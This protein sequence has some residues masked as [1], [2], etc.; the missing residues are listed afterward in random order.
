MIARIW[1]GLARDDGAE[2]Y[3]R[4]LEERVFP[5][6]E[7]LSGYRGS[8]ILRWPTRIRV[9]FAFSMRWKSRG[10]SR[11]CSDSPDRTRISSPT[12]VG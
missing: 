10:P 2:D 5:V 9:L 12:C 8:R 7:G 3:V 1:R 4:H 11:W 6:L